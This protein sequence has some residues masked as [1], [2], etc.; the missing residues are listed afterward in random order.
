MVEQQRPAAREE[1]SMFHLL[2][3][4]LS[5]GLIIGYLY[6]IFSAGRLTLPGFALATL[7]TAAW[8]TLYRLGLKWRGE[9]AVVWGLA[10][11][12]IALLGLL[13]AFLGMGFNWLLPVLTAGFL[14][15]IFGA[16]LSLVL[17]ACLWLGTGTGLVLLD[18]GFRLS[19]QLSILLPFVYAFAFAYTLRRMEV[20]R[21]QAQELVEQLEQSRT[22]LEVAHQQ[23]QQ[24]AVEVEE[25]STTRERNRIAREIHDTLGHYLT[26]LAVQLETAVKLE[27]RGEAGLRGELLEARRVAKECLTE[28]RH[29]VAALRP[30][31]LASGS[32]ESS[33]RRLVADFELAGGGTEVTLD[34]EEK[35]HALS[36]EVRVALYRCAQEA[37]T[38]VRKHARATR[39]LLRL[40]LEDRRV[41][42]T[43]LDN[44]QGAASAGADASSGFGLTGVR[45]R[46]ALLGGAIRTG[47]E[48]E[49]GWRLEA[50]VPLKQEATP[51]LGNAASSPQEGLPS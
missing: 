32:L 19:E 38:N 39:V 43:V 41:E 42:L 8:L 3:I 16:P 15:V 37:L 7:L 25:L 20:A 33:L 14:A 44:G 48:P 6:T 9:L 27:E 5:I 31:D 23:L 28:V 49:H 11:I 17:V 12:V 2:D 35:L 40:R 30:G 1:H 29:S 36:P 21:R 13:P 26:L 47:P 4:V 24:Y 46:I 18:R 45:E 51:S 22:Q 34:L 50:I 10:Y